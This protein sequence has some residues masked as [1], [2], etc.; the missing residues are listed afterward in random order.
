MEPLEI[1]QPNEGEEATQRRSPLGV[2]SLLAV[3]LV[4]FTLGVV[5]LIFLGPSRAEPGYPPKYGKIPE[6]TIWF[7]YDKGFNPMPNRLVDLCIQSFCVNNPDWN[8]EFISDDNVLEYVSAEMLP[9]AYWT[10]KTGANKKDM[11]MANL[12]AIYGGVAADSTI[13]NFRSLNVLWDHMLR[14]GADAVIYWYRLT[15]PW[16]PVDSAAAWFFMAR[17]D[18]GIFRR[19]ARDI[20][21]HFGDAELDVSR[22]GGDPY[23]AFATG[24]LEPIMTEINSSLPLC[25][26]DPT[27]I[28]WDD[29]ATSR[30][31]H[32]ASNAD[33]NNTKVV[34]LDPNDRRHGPQ[35]NTWDVLCINRGVSDCPVPHLS[36][37]PVKE[38]WEQ[39]QSR[40]SDPY[41]T[42]IKL[43]S[44]GGVF[45]KK[46]PD[47]LLLRDED[48]KENIMSKW[49]KDA[50]LK[51]D[52]KN[53]CSA[54]LKKLGRESH[55][56]HDLEDPMV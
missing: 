45:A 29:C 48:E 3:A 28:S 44:G 32:V 39:Y 55:N 30:K 33:L 42:M 52:G 36:E 2:K 51:L 47:L 17:R 13:L 1:E 49:F 10:W 5:T 56:V 25:M 4:S 16:A 38:L 50:G 7:Y 27:R 21:S 15:E 43:F 19:Y 53:P 20:R 40:K 11:V 18:T 34:L 35:L 54:H 12:L 14:D 8:F 41:F 6:K 24:S 23:L 31:Y 46:H 22:V 9:M 37:K 26:N